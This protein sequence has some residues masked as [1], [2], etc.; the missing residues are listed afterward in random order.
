MAESFC[1]RARVQ[2]RV[3]CLAELI[4]S[5]THRADGNSLFIHQP[6]YQR[7]IINGLQIQGPSQPM[8]WRQ[9]SALT[10]VLVVKTIR[11]KFKTSWWINRILVT[12]NVMNMVSCVE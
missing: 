6:L 10:S 7:E 8:K 12:L 5:G 4:N 2:L 3:E 9:R 1:R 11:V